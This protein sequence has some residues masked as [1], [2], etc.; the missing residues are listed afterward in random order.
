[1]PP[2]TI[3]LLPRPEVGI[4]GI[5]VIVVVVG[6][7]AVGLRDRLRS[8]GIS[9]ANATTMEGRIEIQDHR[10]IVTMMMTPLAPNNE[11][12]SER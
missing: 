9:N 8:R 6:A 4:A 10:A 2:M 1:M 5:V 11:D 3:V 7:V 12:D